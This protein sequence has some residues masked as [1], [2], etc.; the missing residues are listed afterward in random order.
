QIYAQIPAVLSDLKTLIAIESVSADLSRAAEV[1]GSAQT[2]V[3]LLMYL[4]CPDVR[5]IRADGGAP[6]VIGR[7]PPPTG[8]PTVCLYAHHD[9]QPEGDPAS[10]R[11]PPFLA[12]EV[13]ARLSG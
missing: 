1:E 5:V 8:M 2:I 4:R 13:G 6:A 10:W 7:F 3:Q 9:V 12:T 11:T